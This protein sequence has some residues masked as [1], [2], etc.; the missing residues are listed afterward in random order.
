MGYYSTSFYGDG[1]RKVYPAVKDIY[2]PTKPIKKFE[3]VN[4][5]QK[6]VGLRL[7]SFEKNTKGLGEQGKLTNT[8]IDKM[9]NYFDFAL[10]SNVGDLTAMKLTCMTSIYH[11]CRYHDNCSKSVDTWCQYQKEK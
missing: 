3:C 10:H 5:Y 6:R 11:V 9:Q 2:C 1:D 7:C 8:K 4:H